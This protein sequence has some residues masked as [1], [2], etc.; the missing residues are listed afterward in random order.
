MSESEVVRNLLGEVPRVSPKRQVVSLI[1]FFDLIMFL[2][3][4]I[5]MTCLD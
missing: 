3:L 1:T 4:I 5:T 2:F